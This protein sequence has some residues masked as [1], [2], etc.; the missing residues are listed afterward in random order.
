MGKLRN[1]DHGNM[2]DEYDF[3]DGDEPENYFDLHYGTTVQVM[4]KTDPKVPVILQFSMDEINWSDG[5]VIEPK[6][7]GHFERRESDVIARYVRVKPTAPTKITATLM[8]KV[9]P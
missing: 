9:T 5:P 7:N 4:G 1:W 6:D 8:G 2:F 3:Q